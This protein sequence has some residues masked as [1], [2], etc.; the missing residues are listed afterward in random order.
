MHIQ[1]LSHFLSRHLDIFRTNISSI[2]A[3]YS[4]IQYGCPR[5]GL[6]SAVTYYHLDQQWGSAQLCDRNVHGFLLSKHGSRLWYY[7]GHLVQNITTLFEYKTV[8]AVV[9]FLSLRW[10]IVNWTQRNKIHFDEILINIAKFLTQDS[11]FEN[12]NCKMVTVASCLNLKI[13]GNIFH[14]N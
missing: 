8:V 9:G 5:A 12:V 2:I 10:L 7:L 6:W 4:L 3:A 13:L 11:L 1:I 14:R